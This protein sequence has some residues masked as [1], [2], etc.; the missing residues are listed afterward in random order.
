MLQP[1]TIQVQ[2]ADDTWLSLTAQGEQWQAAEVVVQTPPTAD[3]GL[4][5]TVL[6]TECRLQRIKLTW[7]TRYAADTLFFGDAFERAYGDLRFT[8]LDEEKPY[9]WYLIAAT[10]HASTCWGVATQPNALCAWTT[11]VDSISLWLDIRSG[12][13]PLDLSHRRL[14]CCTILHHD[15]PKQ[16]PLVSLSDFC[17]RL[18]ADQPT[19]PTEKLIGTND[20]Y[21]AYGNNSKASVLANASAVV[22]LCRDL[23]YRPWVV[24]DDGWQTAHSAEYNGGPW[25][26]GNRKFG[27]MA[28][29]AQAI[30]TLGARPGLWFRPLLSDQPALRPLALHGADSAAFTLDISRS[31]VLAQV[32]EDIRRFKQWGFELVKYDFS[33]FDILQQWGPTMGLTY[34]YGPV[35]FHDQTQTTAE[36]FK[37]L[38]RTIKTAAG[39]MLVMGCNVVSHL[40]AGLIDVMRIGDDTSG[41]AFHRTVAMGVNA[42]AFR[43][44]QHAQFYQVDGDCVGI[45][46]AI[47]WTQNLQWLNLLADSGTPLL[48]SCDFNQLTPEQKQ[49]ITT[50]FAIS[51]AT[52]K[53]L[54]PMHPTQGRYPTKW[55]AEAQTYIYNW[56]YNLLEKI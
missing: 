32:A 24:I 11:T 42:L 17:Q 19:P 5:V 43:M 53:L 16:S 2:T 21:Y 22:D 34:A 45:T 13:A 54:L 26:S 7:P 18:N 51:C 35:I 4:Q 14:D 52:T 3:A 49:D 39:A 47:P 6:P 20:W 1:T 33:C 48:V 8:P 9:Y 41:R 27:D 31:E 37:R 44:P 56:Q 12:T 28:A 30:K 23:P 46:A 29:T 38:Y 25:T 40:A 50:A 15:Y 36:L 10:A 55:Q